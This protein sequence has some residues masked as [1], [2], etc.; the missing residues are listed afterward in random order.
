MKKNR[1][2][3]SRTTHNK[4]NF[5]EN[6]P[7]GSVELK[8][9]SRGLSSIVG[10]AIPIF[11]RQ[12]WFFRGDTDEITGFD[13]MAGFTEDEEIRLGWFF[14]CRKLELD[15]LEHDTISLRFEHAT[16]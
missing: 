7:I 3:N 6:C 11:D 10:V 5:D 4:V 9:T 15:F 8:H 13:P 14:E 12:P 16:L 1:D 2:E